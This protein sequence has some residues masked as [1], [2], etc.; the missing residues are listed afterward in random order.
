MKPYVPIVPMW[1]KRPSFFPAIANILPVL[2]NIFPVYLIIF[3]VLVNIFPVYLIIFPVLSI[4]LP[5]ILTNFPVFQKQLRENLPS[6][7]EE[8]FT[9]VITLNP[10]G[11][12]ITSP[13]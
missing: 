2:V 3:P 7:M 4:I 11:I 1:F 13:G 9:I 12:V 8:L 6:V 5:V 10:L